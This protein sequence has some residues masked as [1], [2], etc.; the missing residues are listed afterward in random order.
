MS[1]TTCICIK[2]GTRY[3]P[4][5][6]NRL[7][8]GLR[9]HASSDIRLLCMTE[10]RAGLHPGIEILPLAEEPFHPAMFAAMKRNG[11]GAPYR[12]VSLY[13]RDLVPDLDGPLILLDIDVVIVGDITPLRDFGPGK[14][15]MRRAWDRRPG[16]PQLGH[17]SVEKFEPARHGYIYDEL[18]RDPEAALVFGH[19]YEQIFTSR[20]AEKHGD[21]LAFPDEWIASFKYD[22]RPPRPL[23]MILPPRLPAGARVVC[24]HG[25]PKMHEAVEGY[26]SDPLH[27]TRRARW[28]TE[29]WRD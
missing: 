17:G 3:G 14:V 10:D 21:F 27:M 16:T 7:R 8:A 2:Y 29:A 25:R 22:C 1:V 28:L 13:R 6:P 15:C 20:T 23:N 5:Y 26:F 19:G 11:W 4:E 18:A 9:R 24:F 12:K